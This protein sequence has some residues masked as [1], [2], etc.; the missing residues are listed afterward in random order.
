MLSLYLRS[1]KSVA[2]I[3]RQLTE[4]LGA[5]SRNVFSY[6]LIKSSKRVINLDYLAHMLRPYGRFVAEK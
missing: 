1:L 3:R 5:I 2:E 6:S 4:M